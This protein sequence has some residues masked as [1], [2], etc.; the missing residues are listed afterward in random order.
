MKWFVAIFIAIVNCAAYIQA[1]TAEARHTH[2]VFYPGVE[3]QPVL[4]LKI[5]GTAGEKI[6]AVKINTGE[7]SS[8]CKIKVARLSSSGN[9]N[10][11][12][13]HTQNPVQQK[14]EKKTVAPAINTKVTTNTKL[15]GDF[16]ANKGKLPFPVSKG[17]II[18]KIIPKG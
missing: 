4:Q 13:T 15:S 1:A 14:A 5:C 6:T 12:T 2:S 8:G 17:V 16:A 10:M 18:E 3:N 11:F 9:R 7:T